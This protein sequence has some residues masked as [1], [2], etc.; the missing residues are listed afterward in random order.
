MTQPKRCGRLVRLSTKPPSQGWCIAPRPAA[1]NRVWR[2]NSRARNKI[3]KSGEDV[4][5]DFAADIG[6]AKIA[7]RVAVG[8]FFVVEPQEVEHGGVEVVDMN[9]VF[10]RAE[11]EFVGRAMDIAALDSTT[12]QPNGEAVVVMVASFAF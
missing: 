6:Q 12:R 10:G 8:E 9:R 2:C 5:D 11:A 7:A 3:K 1:R 4:L